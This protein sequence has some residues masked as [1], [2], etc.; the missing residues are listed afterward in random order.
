MT[1]I[2]SMAGAVAILAAGFVPVRNLFRWLRKASRFIDEVVGEPEQFGRPARPGAI[3]RM[4]RHEVAVAAVAVQL[5]G[6]I[7]EL[8]PNSGSSLR[9]AV[10]RLEGKATEAA[11]TAAEVKKDLAI[12]TTLSA[13]Q[14][15]AGRE[16]SARVWRTFDDHN[17]AITT[18]AEAVKVAALSTPPDKDE[19]QP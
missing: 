2:L 6:I 13:E 16:E 19:S 5:E 17:A 3:E 12:H 10:D 7:H 8:H 18:L 9:D 14:M 1:L 11:N 15:L 4:D